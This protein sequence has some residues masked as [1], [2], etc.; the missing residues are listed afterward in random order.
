MDHCMLFWRSFTHWIGG[1]GVL[2]FMLAILPMAG[3]Q[4]LHLMRAESP[5]PP[6]A[7][8]CRSCASRPSGSTGFIWACL[9]S[10]LLLWIGGMPAFEALCLTF[11]YRRHRRHLRC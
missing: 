11:W 1:M 3:G 6:W 4:N 5:A 8:W 9:W 2:V 7:S 10:F